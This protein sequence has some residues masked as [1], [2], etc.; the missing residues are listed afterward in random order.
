M[1][2]V[3]TISPCQYGQKR[4][5]PVNTKFKNGQEW[6]VKI[7]KTGQKKRVTKRLKMVKNSQKWSD[8]I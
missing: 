5:K 1:D 8:T 4:F 3:N 2:V 7:V 6:S